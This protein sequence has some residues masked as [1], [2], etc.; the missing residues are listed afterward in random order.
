M[1]LQLVY[2]TFGSKDEARRIAKSLVESRLAACANIIDNMNS[3]Y[4]WKGEL[5]DDT[6]TILIAKTTGQKV[7]P[8]IDAVK[9]AHSYDLPCMVTLPISGGYPPFLKWIE[10]ETGQSG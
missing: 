7:K 3:F 10:D 6:E 9:S 4:F 2:M 5:Q 1:D 8:L